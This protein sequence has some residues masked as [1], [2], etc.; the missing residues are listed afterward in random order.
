MGAGYIDYIVADARVIPPEHQAYYAEKVV[1]LPDMYQANDSKRAIA[2]RAPTR[3]EAGL[4]DAGFVFSCF[5]KN[6]KIMPDMFDLWMRLLRGVQGSVLWLLEANDVATRN[7]RRE[8]ERRGVAP[9]RLVFAPRVR[10]DE[11]LARHRLA[12]L[13]L[14]TLP[15]NAHTTASDALWAGLPIL[16][17]MGGAFPGR[18]AA[19][20]LCAAGLPELVT[21]SRGEYEELAI[22]LATDPAALAAIK[23]RLARNRAT[24]A[25]FDTDRA[26]GHL[27]SA[28]ATMW[29]RHQRGEPPAGFSVQAIS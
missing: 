13:F 8:A 14:D 6:Y 12:D 28:Y 3:A 15:Y 7:L 19:S 1:Y 21:H 9:E 20:L 22:R 5:N 29:E 24:C 4:P 18:V 26:R 10:P 23:A 25:L 2:D 11:H 16:T 27:E 17:C